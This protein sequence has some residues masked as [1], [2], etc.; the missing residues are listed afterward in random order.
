MWEC[1]LTRFHP[2]V[3][4][5]AIFIAIPFSKTNRRHN[6][7]TEIDLFILPTPYCV[8]NSQGSLT[9]K[10]YIHFQ[11]L[12]S[13][14]SWWKSGLSIMILGCIAAAAAYGISALAEHAVESHKSGTIQVCSSNS[15]SIVSD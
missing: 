9:C 12:S 11:S 8:I 10:R 15:T 5:C 7:Q 2:Q 14:M 4:V 13:Y 3:V 6:F 1:A